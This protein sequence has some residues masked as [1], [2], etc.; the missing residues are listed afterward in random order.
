MGALAGDDAGA[1]RAP[2]PPP[3]PETAV[4]EARR[5]TAPAAAR[6]G[7][8]RPPREQGD[9]TTERRAAR[10]RTVRVPAEKLDVLL[11][12]VGETVLHRQRLGHLVAS[13]DAAQ[14]E[15]LADELDLG[16]RLLG[17]LQDAALQTRTL[18]FGSITGPFPRAIR[19]S[20]NAEGKEVDLVVRGDGDRTRPRDPR[21]THGAARAHAAQCRRPRHRGAVPSDR[22][23][24]SRRAGRSCSARSSAAG[25]VAVTVSDDGRGV[26]RRAARA[27]R[28]RGLARGCPG[29]PG[30]LDA[31]RGE[32]PR[33]SRRRVRRRQGARREL[34]RHDGDRERARRG[35][36]RH[37]APA[38]HARAARRPAR[39]ARLARLRRSRSRACRRR[40]R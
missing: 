28:R 20:A 22:R 10:G 16:D 30:V 37:A 29:A 13:G 2:E 11:D 24:A 26:S 25:I 19:D 39:R 9:A 15:D 18:P 3:A 32:R 40:S 36:A 38:A 17:A 7:R 14:G 8:R 1:T 31:R 6:R 34:R 21:R 5:W 12:L 33:G 27:G 35:H 23:P 4:A